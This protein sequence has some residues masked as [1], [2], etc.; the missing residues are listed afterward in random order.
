M[1]RMIGHLYM[2]LLGTLS[3]TG[4]FMLVQWLFGQ[5]A[6]IVWVVFQLVVA[7]W[8]VYGLI[9]APVYDD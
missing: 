1:K 5:T 3:V 2:V 8:M 7:A 9:R 6:A 4:H